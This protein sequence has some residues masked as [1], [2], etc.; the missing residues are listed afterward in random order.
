[1]KI[2]MKLNIVPVFGFICLVCSSS[3]GSSQGYQSG[4]S[5]IV[6]QPTPSPPP[7]HSSSMSNVSGTRS[8][9]TIGGPASNQ[10]SQGNISG[11]SHPSAHT[12]ETLPFER[13]DSDSRSNDKR[14]NTSRTS[15]S[16]GGCTWCFAG[17]SR[18]R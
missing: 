4:G 10:G 18:C 12:Y 14:D 9:A 1:M 16:N 13:S 8:Y 3:S 6:N 17:C 2:T 11:S 15:E 7:S 5:A